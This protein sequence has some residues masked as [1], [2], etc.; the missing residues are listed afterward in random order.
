MNRPEITLTPEQMAFA[1]TVG[2]TRY[3]S[4]IAR[5]LQRGAPKGE[6]AHIDGALAECAAYLHY[7]PITWSAREMG[8][9]KPDLGG[10]IDVKWRGHSDH[11]LIIQLKGHPE[12][13]YLLVCGAAA[14]RYRIMGWVWGNEAMINR[15]RWEGGHT[16]AY[17]IPGGILRSPAS[18]MVEIRRRQAS[19]LE[20]VAL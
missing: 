18:L 17:Y 19:R 2:R 11:K 14:P 6:Q 9:D 5:D 8:L 7:R 10:F 16:P 4:A 3:A 20:G 15:W 13:A 1:R 12:W